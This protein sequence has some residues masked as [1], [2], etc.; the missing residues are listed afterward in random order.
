MTICKF[1]ELKMETKH[2]KP[3]E[4][5]DRLHNLS[6]GAQTGLGRRTLMT[7]N[8]CINKERWPAAEYHPA[9]S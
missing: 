2:L 8:A 7:I 3:E 9:G 6:Y 4:P 1:R 5:G